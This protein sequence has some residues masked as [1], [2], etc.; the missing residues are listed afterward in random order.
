MGQT[1][2]NTIAIIGISCHYP[3]AETLLQLWENILSRRQQ[4]RSP[5]NIRLPLSDYYDSDPKTSDKTYGSRMAVIDGF[6]F[7]WVKHRIPKKT[8][9]SS[10]IVHWLAL[11]TAEKALEDA[12]Y[13]RETVP[14]ELAG[15]IL[16]NTLT[17]EQTRAETMRLR[18]PF[19][20]K[21]LRAAAQ[22]KG[23]P[24][25]T[26]ETLVETM[27][28]FYKSVFAP[29]TED[30]LAGGLA[31]TIAGRICNFFNLDG[32]GYNVDGACSSSVI[33]VADACSKLASGDLNMALAGGKE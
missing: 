16:G 9:E 21:T 6:E 33:A 7:D 2:N 13:S 27:E 1:K 19:V 5:P 26:T 12:G 14:T 11:D 8:I 28:K 30:S 24:Q 25:A 29:I 10:D 22:A 18:W 23:L 31:N 32:G 20:R 15:V 17:G 4:F 3:G